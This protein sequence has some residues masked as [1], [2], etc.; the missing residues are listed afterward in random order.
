MPLWKR[1]HWLKKTYR[2][3]IKKKVVSELPKFK[4]E[5]RVYDKVAK[6][7]QDIGSNAKGE[8]PAEIFHYSGKD[9]KMLFWSGGSVNVQDV[10]DFHRTILRRQGKGNKEFLEDCANVCL[11]SDGVKVGSHGEMKNHIFSIR[12]GNHIYPIKV[13]HLRKKKKMPKEAPADAQKF[14]VCAYMMDCIQQVL[15]DKRLTL[16]FIICDMV[17]RRVL[18]GNKAST[19]KDACETCLSKAAKKGGWLYQAAKRLH[20]IRTPASYRAAGERVDDPDDPA[21][22]VDGINYNSPLNTI[23][24][25]RFN[26][27]ACM[28]PDEVSMASNLFEFF[29]SSYVISLLAALDPR[30]EY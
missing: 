27:V 11:S 1:N 12:L 28:P 29:R 7:V 18:R 3:N 24:E 16:R 17:E 15:D 22:E 26:I 2:H 6:T 25:D 23:D 21:T 20:I 10:V 5:A 9:K 19:S 30:R 4:Y 13:F 14:D 8:L